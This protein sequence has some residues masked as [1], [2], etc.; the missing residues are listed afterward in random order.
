MLLRQ[1]LLYLPAQLLGPLSQFIAALVWTHMISVAD[2]GHLMIVLSA[3]ELV[4]LVCVSWWTQYTMRYVGTIVDRA[5]KRQFLAAE[6]TVLL[7]TGVLQILVVA[8][9]IVCFV[10]GWSMALMAAAIVYTLSRC[11]LTHLAERS[12]IEGD[13]AAYTIAQTVGPLG[14]TLLGFLMIEFHAADPVSALGGYAIAQV[15]SLAIVWTRSR[16]G[17]AV[18]RPSQALLAAAGRYGAPL[19]LAGAFG[20]SSL[21]GIRLIVDYTDG[22][23]AVGLLSVGWGLGQRAISVVAMLV[24]AAAY[25]LALRHMNE[26]ARDK[27]FDQVSLNGALLLGVLAPAAAGVIMVGNLVIGLMVAEPFQAMSFV[28]LP[29]AVIAAALRN[30]RVH[31]LDQVLFLV[32]R[33]DRLLRVN[34]VEAV[35]TFAFC[36]AGLGVWGLPGAAFGC[37]PGTLVG[38]LYCYVQT[39][40]YGLKLPLAHLAKIALATAGMVLGLRLMPPGSGIA[41]IVA[42]IAVGAAIYSIA[43]GL[44]YGADVRRWRSRSA[45]ASPASDPAE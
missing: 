16:Q 10:D 42:D 4:S 8:V 31:F 34:A 40:R 23:A 11:L 45:L 18:A 28:I 1:T 20:W 43:M 29:I 6:N 3:Q 41:T 24:T 26:G 7:A 19:L 30:A 14:G 22:P 21:N 17:L 39:A 9:V 13:I 36:V 25:P 37:I 15:A 5:E 2:Y 38:L 33:P 27:S 32:E 44:L 35:A 12:R